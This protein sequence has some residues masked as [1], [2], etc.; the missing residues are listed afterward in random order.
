MLCRK[1]KTMNRVLQNA[2]AQALY[3]EQRLKNM[4]NDQTFAING[5]TFNM[6]NIRNLRITG[7][8]TA[9][10]ISDDIEKLT[11]HSQRRD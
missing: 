3:R 7:D 6:A 5:K 11:Y 10:W 2:L 8:V 1:L 9:T 4:V